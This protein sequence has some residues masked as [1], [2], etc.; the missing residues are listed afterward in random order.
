MWKGSFGIFDDDTAEITRVSGVHDLYMQLDDPTAAADIKTIRIDR[1]SPVPQ[2]LSNT[3]IGSN[4][5]TLRW[6]DESTEVGGFIVQWRKALVKPANAPKDWPTPRQYIGW[7]IAP[8]TKDA[9][10]YDVKNLSAST[11]YEFRV[12]AR[13]SSGGR[14]SVVARVRTKLAKGS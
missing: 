9:R 14:P 10:S 5:V 1:V 6:Q 13:T 3:E 2:I 12:I 4:Q 8:A 7:T 11:D